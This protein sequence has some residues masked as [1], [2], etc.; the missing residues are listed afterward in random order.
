MKRLFAILA[1]ACVVMILPGSMVASAWAGDQAPPGPML[2]GAD[3]P[4][5]GDGPS[6]GADAVFEAQGDPDELGGGFRNSVKP[7]INNNDKAGCGGRQ[8][9]DSLVRLVLRLL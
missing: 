5:A 3:Q 9:L 2:P 4:S 1:L 6:D 8:I 7:P